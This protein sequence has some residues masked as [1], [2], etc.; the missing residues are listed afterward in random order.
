MGYESTT[1]N[2]LIIDDDPIAR[3]LAKRNLEIAG[4]K[5]SIITADNGLVG[6]DVIKNSIQNFIVLLDFHM[7]ELDGLG[8][9]QKLKE[10]DIEL[11]IF[12]LSSSIHSQNQNSCLSFSGVQE[13]FVK[14]IDQF[15]TKTVLAF[16]NN[17][18]R[19]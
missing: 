17:Y 10:N 4:F 19:V 16:A 14:P 2:I 18:S 11:P 5:G 12:M 8:L 6:F 7:P 1:R 3:M 15:K 13:F 9:L